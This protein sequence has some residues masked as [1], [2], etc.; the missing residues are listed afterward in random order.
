MK[1]KCRFITL[2]TRFFVSLYFCW[3]TPPATQ[4]G[5]NR[6]LPPS[7]QYRTRCSQHFHFLTSNNTMKHALVPAGPYK[8]RKRRI[9]ALRRVVLLYKIR[10]RALL[11]VLYS[12][13]IPSMSPECPAGA[14]V[15]FVK[16][17]I[18]AKN[19]QLT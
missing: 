16:L 9:T 3:Q 15:I 5:E 10:L 13:H 14:C 6:C 18:I 17:T 2:F 11:C 1:E 8:T 7:L 12:T 4:T 19:L